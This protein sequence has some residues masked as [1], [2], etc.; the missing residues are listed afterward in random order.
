MSE[1]GRG[2]AGGAKVVALLVTIFILETLD[3]LV[4]HG[5]AVTPTGAARTLLGAV[6]LA[7]FLAWLGPRIHLSL[8]SLVLLVWLD[9]FAVEYMINYVEGV[10][11]TTMFEGS[12]VSTVTVIVFAALVSGIVAASAAFL[13]GRQGGNTGIRASL[14][15][16][17]STRTARSWVIR[18]VVASVVYFPIYFF[19]GL[20]VT[21]FVMPYYNNPSSGLVIPSFAVMVPVELFRGFLFVLVLLPLLVATTGG[22]NTKFVALA[23]MLYIPGGFVALL[24]GTSIPPQIIP[25]HATEILADS[26]VY[27]FVLSR[28]L[29]RGVKQA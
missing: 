22:R 6:V 16:H 13:M 28:I 2:V 7:I 26:I 15:E 19:F 24:G 10:F 14:K 11:F 21:P 23:A 4:V 25:F 8:R 27:G 3:N 29:Q 9:L 17:L 12:Y 20:L 18:I 1:Q 5:V